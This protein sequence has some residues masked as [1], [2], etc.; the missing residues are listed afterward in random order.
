M[1]SPPGVDLHC[2]TNGYFDSIGTDLINVT[3]SS[4]E[5]T[6]ETA[7]NT[8]SRRVIDC[9]YHGTC[10]PDSWMIFE[11]LEGELFCLKIVMSID[12]DT[13]HVI[14]YY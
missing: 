1:Q 6:S 5:P 4:E 14:D 10:P 3:A 12:G 11:D 8:T 2:Q 9:L 13:D 7:P